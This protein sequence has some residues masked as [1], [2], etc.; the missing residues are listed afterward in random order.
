MKSDLPRI[1]AAR[2][3]TY[4]PRV[5]LLH[6]AGGCHHVWHY[7]VK[8]LGRQARVFALDLPGHCKSEPPAEYTFPEFVHL[9][10][11][12]FHEAL[13]GMPEVLVG[14]SMGGLLALALAARNPEIQ[15]L[16][17][18]SAALRIPVQ[19]RRQPVTPEEVEEICRRIY[20]QERWVRWCV[21]HRSQVILSTPPVML[22]DLEMVRGVDLRPL[23]PEIRQPVHFAVGRYDEVVTAPLLQETLA[24]LPQARLTWLEQSG[25]MPHLEEAGRVAEI[26]EEELQHVQGA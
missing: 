15:R 8:R 1:Y 18:L 23:A 24:L 4:G 19:P 21:E 10:S 11:R 7:F 20:H 16:V 5:V 13:G 26:I 25:H 22:K 9:L 12:W 17:V 14:H 6:G 3:G 2:S